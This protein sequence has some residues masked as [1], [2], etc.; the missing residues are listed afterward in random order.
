VIIAAAAAAN[1]GAFP[2]ISRAGQRQLP[3]SAVQLLVAGAAGDA[4]R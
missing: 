3:P 1:G 4:G 2:R